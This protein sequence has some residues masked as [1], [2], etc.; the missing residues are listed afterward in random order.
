MKTKQVIIIRRDLN[1]GRGKEISQG[2][3][4]SMAF[5]TKHLKPIRQKNPN[6]QGLSLTDVEIFWLKSSF[7]KITLQVQTEQELLELHE[8]AKIA[9]LESNLIT[10]SGLTYFKGAPT[11]TCLAIGPDYDSKID[12]ITKHLKLY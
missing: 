2:S 9:G 1:M 4:A 3:H 12:K 6:L 8:S 5:L 10:D 11:I 7:R